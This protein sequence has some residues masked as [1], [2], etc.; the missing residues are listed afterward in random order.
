MG[1]ELDYISDNAWNDLVKSFDGVYSNTDVDIL[2]E[3]MN[4]ARDM[5][6][7]INGKIGLKG[8]L[9][10]MERKV[11]TLENIR[12]LD[13]LDDP[14]LIKRLRQYLIELPC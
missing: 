6:I 4:G 1:L 2:T 11:K 8:G 12:P 13:C 3:K 14:E 9:E 7:V 5:A 10:W